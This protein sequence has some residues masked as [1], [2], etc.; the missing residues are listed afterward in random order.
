MQRIFWFNL[1]KSS[2]ETNTALR[3][4]TSLPKKHSKRDK[5]KKK[6]FESS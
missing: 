1:I 5:K 4:E 2:L 3:A 6:L